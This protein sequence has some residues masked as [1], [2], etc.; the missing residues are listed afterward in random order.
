VDI[1]R[2]A[3]TT[4]VV[5]APGLGD[6]IQAIK[7]GILE[8]ADVLVVNKADHPGVESTER[9]LR[10]MLELAH[11]LARTFVH[12]GRVEQIVTAASMEAALWIPPIQRTIATD[13]VG[14]AELAEAIAKHRAHLEESGGWQRVERVRLQSELDMLLQEALVACWRSKVPENVY[15][16]VVD[17][18]VERSISPHQAVEK[19]APCMS[20]A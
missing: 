14:I 8:I 15:L 11:P 7:A 16:E 2:L 18:L 12:H 4:L 17:R 1:A 6:D 19:L 9:A 20:Q 5:E 3:H 13:G 10:G